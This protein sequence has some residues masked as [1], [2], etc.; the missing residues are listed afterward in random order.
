MSDKSHEPVTEATR[1]EATRPE[2]DDQPDAAGS[3]VT[4]AGDYVV[5][6][7]TGAAGRRRRIEAC[8]QALVDKGE[9]APDLLF[10][11][12]CGRVYDDVDDGDL[13][14]ADDAFD[15]RVADAT[16]CNATKGEGLPPPTTG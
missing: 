11:L 16:E 12:R 9:L 3:G 4:V 5:A 8:L 2:A 10:E 7:A 14:A 1:P 15:Q 13:T 6:D